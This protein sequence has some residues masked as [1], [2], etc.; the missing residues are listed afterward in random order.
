MFEWV[1][2]QLEKIASPTLDWVQVEV[3]TYCNGACIYFPI[4]S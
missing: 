2:R 3:T 1:K 4:P